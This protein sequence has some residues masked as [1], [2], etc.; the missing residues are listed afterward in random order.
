[1]VCN[2]YTYAA[3]LGACLFTACSKP[4][5]KVSSADAAIELTTVKYDALKA[6][7]Q[8]HKGKIVVLDVWG[9]F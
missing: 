9:D 2:R 5:S 7:I 8:A 4:T 6:A 1:M 3:V